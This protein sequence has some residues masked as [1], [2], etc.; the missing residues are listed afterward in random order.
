M[1]KDQFTGKVSKPGEKLRKI[2]VEK[3]EKVYHRTV[4]D[5]ETGKP[6]VVEVGRGWEIVKELSLSEE[7]ERLYLLSHP[8]LAAAG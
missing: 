2:V 3:R 1:F 7:G 5:M 6:M 4:R 8:P